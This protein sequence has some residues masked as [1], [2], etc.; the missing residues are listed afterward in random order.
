MGYPSENQVGYHTYSLGGIPTTLEDSVHGF[1]LHAQQRAQ[2]L[3]NVSTACRELGISRT[4]FYRWKRR[5]E[6]YGPD[7]LH[8]HGV[9]RHVEAPSTEPA[10]NS[11]SS[12]LAPEA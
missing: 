10:R 4:V 2:G 5:F 9:E 11:G 12:T 7:G 8:G 3:G 1:R 6:R